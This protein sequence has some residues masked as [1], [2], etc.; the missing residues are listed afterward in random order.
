MR[1]FFACLLTL[2][3][4][5]CYAQEPIPVTCEQLIEASEEATY[6]SIQ[7]AKAGEWNQSFQYDDIVFQNLILALSYCKGPKLDQARKYLKDHYKI[8]NELTC[9]FHINAAREYMVRGQFAA[10]SFNDYDSA[11]RLIG[12][13][14]YYIDEAIDRCDDR[15]RPT[16]LS[17]RKITSDLLE[18][19]DRTHGH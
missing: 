6:L 14:L 13:S 19:V 17:L 11:A 10:K 9:T 5:L 7:A 8:T 3:G 4:S 12:W 16:L 2:I 1:I 18:T 15:K